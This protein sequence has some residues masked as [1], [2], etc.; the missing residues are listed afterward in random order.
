MSVK[1][2]ITFVGSGLLRQKKKGNTTVKSWCK[3][4]RAGIA[5]FAI[6]I[7]ST[8]VLFT[9]SLAKNRSKTAKNLV[10]NVEIKLY[11]DLKSMMGKFDYN[12]FTGF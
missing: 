2:K 11:L 1:G 4:T 10:V 7:V 9:D 6:K 3:A 8:N 5:F 12:Q